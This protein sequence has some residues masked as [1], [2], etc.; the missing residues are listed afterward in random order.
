MKHSNKKL[1]S[2]WATGLCIGLLIAGG[3]FTVWER[4]CGKQALIDFTWSQTKHIADVVGSS[5]S[6][7]AKGDAKVILSSLTYHR[8]IAYAGVYDKDGNLFAEYYGLNLAP[9]SIKPADIPEN[10]PA[11]SG[12]YLIISEPIIHEGRDLGK[13]CIWTKWQ[14]RHPVHSLLHFE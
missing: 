7:G 2:F 6:F 11:F 1:M 5:V 12:D 8:S 3:I 14:P 13:V 9:G 10:S 4:H